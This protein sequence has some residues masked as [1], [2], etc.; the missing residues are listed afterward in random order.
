[1]LLSSQQTRPAREALEQWQKSDPDN[2]APKALLAWL[3]FGEMQDAAGIAQLK[4]AAR[5][6]EIDY[7]YPEMIAAQ[8]KALRAG[9]MTEFDAAF[10][11]MAALIMPE[12]AALREIARIAVYQ[13]YQA[14][15]GGQS[16][17]A[18][19]NWQDVMTL[20]RKLRYQDNTGIGKLVGLAVEAIGASPVYKWSTRRRA[21]ESG[22][23]PAYPLSGKTGRYDGGDI[24]QGKSYDFFVKYAGP[25]AA[26]RVLAG[27]EQGQKFR[28]L[29]RPYFSGEVGPGLA[30]ALIP[31]GSGALMLIEAGI[32]LVLALLAGL[33][34]RGRKEQIS[35]HWVWAIL[36][37]LVALSPIWLYT[38][39]RILPQSGDESSGDISALI[40]PTPGLFYFVPP[41]ALL[42][43]L[44]LASLWI[45]LKAKEIPAFGRLYIGLL[46][47]TARI[48]LL[49][50]ALSY[51]MLTVHTAKLRAEGI[52]QIET[53]I[54]QGELAHLRREHPELFA[55]PKVRLESGR[56]GE[57]II[58]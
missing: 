2:A 13:G 31:L 14:Q 35:L 22:M 49:L 58:K 27:L 17:R 5:A 29:A 12:Y 20:G 23:K 3:D 41:I 7:Y 33:L 57:G 32:F 9:G 48:C 46:R 34:T 21:E 8:S 38:L 1:L 11:G 51:A 4:A 54:T 47:Q 55:P 43:F 37:A 39:A 24:Y 25:K 50:L 30:K 6:P 53:H 40:R 52:K 45:W 36:L 19:E 16:Q 42:F 10:N 26:A 15:T 28:Q 18:M 56:A 44:S